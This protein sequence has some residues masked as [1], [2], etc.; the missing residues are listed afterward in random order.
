M[1]GWEKKVVVKPRDWGV[2]VGG[3]NA[4]QDEMSNWLLFYL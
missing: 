4:S 2:V 3:I 1:K